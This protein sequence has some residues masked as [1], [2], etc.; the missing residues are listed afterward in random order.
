MKFEIEIRNLGFEKMKVRR[1]K[2][3]QNY[4]KEDKDASFSV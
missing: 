3:R 4:E 1:E 2:K